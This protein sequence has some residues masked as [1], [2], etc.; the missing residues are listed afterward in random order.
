MFGLSG[1]SYSWV[2]L[3][4][5]ASANVL[6][7]GRPLCLTERGDR[8][9]WS[10]RKGKGYW[11]SR[12]Q[13]RNW[14]WQHR[15]V[16]LSALIDISW[17]RKLLYAYESKAKLRGRANHFVKLCF[18]KC[19][20]GA[21]Y[22]SSATPADH[23]FKDNRPWVESNPGLWQGLRETREENRHLGHMESG[24]VPPNCSSF[25]NS[26]QCGSTDNI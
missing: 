17:N 1:C 25:M 6:S 23:L 5:T 12:M 9:W 20:L 8:L 26:S 19:P 4:L 2:V 18:L 24:N 22:H 21:S 14:P 13:P 11:Q 16:V 15:V 3:S 7:L 10:C